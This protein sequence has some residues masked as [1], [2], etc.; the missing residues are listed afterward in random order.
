MARYLLVWLT[1]IG[2]SVAYRRRVN[3]G[4]DVVFTRLPAAGRRLASL[5]MHLA[6]AAFFLVMIV[7]GCRFAWFVRRQIS[8]AVSLPKWLVFSVIPLSGLL[9]LVH[10]VYFFLAELAGKREDD[11]P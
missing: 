6:A 7:Y 3:P 10:A 5:A 2:A 9:L 4:I 1:F 8:P 11:G